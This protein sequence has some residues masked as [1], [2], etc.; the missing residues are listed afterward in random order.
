MGF[1]TYCLKIWH[2]GL[3]HIWVEDI[4]EKAGAGRT[5]DLHLKWFI[6]PSNEVTLLISYSLRKGTF[7]FQKWR[8]IER[9]LNAHAMLSFPQFLTNGSAPIAYQISS[10][11]STLHQMWNKESWALKNW[12]F[13]TMA[14]VP[15]HEPPSHF[16]PHNISLGYPHAPAPSMLYPASDIDWR[17]NSYMIV[18]ML[19]CHSP[20]SS[21]PLAP[22]ESKS[23]LY[24]SV[25]LSLS[26]IQGHHCHLPKF[27]IYVLVYCIGVFLSGLLHSV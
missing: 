16:P 26:F 9:H 5:S 13:W 17:F 25:S 19:E 10:P 24:T 1:S 22:S 27:H 18:Y 21:H 11:L 2:F 15:K 12:C 8:N 20:K 6:K 3:L 7:L 14:C 4:C 23:P